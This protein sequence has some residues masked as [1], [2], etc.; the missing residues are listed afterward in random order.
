MRN[1]LLLALFFMICRVTQA[2]AAPTIEYFTVDNLALNYPAVERGVEAANFSW[3]AVGLRDGDEMQ[4]HAWVGGQW[5]VIGTG[6]EPEKTDRLVIAH[7]LDYILPR[8]RLSVVDSTGTIVAEQ[9]LELNYAPPEGL[10][11]ISM[12]TTFPADIRT[13]KPM[14]F[15]LPLHI[16]WQVTNRWFNS[17]IVFEQVMPDGTVLDAEVTRPGWQYAHKDDYVNI[18]YPGDYADVVLQLRVINRDDNS[19]LVKKSLVLHVVNEEIPQPEMVNFAVSAETIDPGGTLTLAWE[20]AN[21]DVVFIEYHDGNPNGSCAGLLEAV[22][23]LP[24]DGTLDV[25]VPPLSDN[26]YLEFYLFA[27]YYLPGSRHNCGSRQTPLGHLTVDLTDYRGQG[28]E[29]FRAEP[30]I[31]ESGD[32]ITLSWSVT[33]GESV[34]IRYPIMSLNNTITSLDDLPTYQTFE[35]LPLT[36]TLDL[37]IPDSID[38]ILTGYLLL[39]I[40]EEGTMPPAHDR[41]TSLIYRRPESD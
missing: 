27:D 13:I 21:T 7:P 40:I 18:V 31:V 1:I 33:E 17:S 24:A 19:T 6:F 14:A 11:V 23:E 9:I 29:Y 34:T 25:T 20:V 30:Y 4:M 22:W 8:Y 36:G 35:H 10:P 39:Y 26:S 38:D 12:F 2:Q 16:Q 28:V 15:D 41:N 37:T 3:R 5:V 32:T